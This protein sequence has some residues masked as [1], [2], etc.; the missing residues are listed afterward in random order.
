MDQLQSHQ[1]ILTPFNYHEWKSKVVLLLRSKGLYRITMGKEVEPNSQVEKTKWFNKLDE[2]YGLLCLSISSDLLFHVE[3]ASFPN[4]VWT[5]LEGLFGKQD[6]LRGHQ[7]ENEII[8]LI[9][10]DFDIFQDLFT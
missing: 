6:V 7:L 1:I 3:S 8:I 10:S 5:K 4:E 2:A 9:P